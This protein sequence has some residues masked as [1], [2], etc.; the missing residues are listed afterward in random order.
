MQICALKK[1]QSES[2]SQ[3]Y[4]ILLRKFKINQSISYNETQLC[5]HYKGFSRLLLCKLL[6]RRWKTNR[7]FLFIKWEW[8]VEKS[9][10]AASYYY[11]IPLGINFR[12]N[13]AEMHSNF[14]LL[15]REEFCV[16]KFI[17]KHAFQEDKRCIQLYQF[18]CI[19][20]W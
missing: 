14:S 9:I 18:R 1:N 16:F 17:W 15:D 6:T 8:D 19:F 12:Q 11:F 3:Y 20:V 13:N 2:A 10:S 5:Y 4:S 7:T